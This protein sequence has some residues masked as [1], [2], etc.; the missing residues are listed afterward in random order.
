[1]TDVRSAVIQRKKAI[2]AMNEE[3]NAKSI[4][5]N[6][7]KAMVDLS[8]TAHHPHRSEDNERALFAADILR[9]PRQRKANAVGYSYSYSGGYYGTFQTGKPVS[10]EQHKAN[11]EAALRLGDAKNQTTTAVTEEE[12]GFKAIWAKYKMHILILLVIVFGFLA[13]K[14]L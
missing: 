10:E 1:M 2:Q 5:L 7:V 11:M 12:G 8:S 3:M 6:P 9:N 14:Y 4:R 13:Y